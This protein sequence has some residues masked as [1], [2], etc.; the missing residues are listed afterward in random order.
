MRA[1][2]VIPARG[3]RARNPDSSPS[4]HGKSTV[5]DGREQKKARLAIILTPGESEKNEWA[6]LDKYVTIELHNYCATERG[7]NTLR[8]R[9]CDASGT[10]AASGSKTAS[11]R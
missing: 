7:S 4:T 10:P 5:S 3:C 6:A 2:S 11:S 1:F 8:A 9:G